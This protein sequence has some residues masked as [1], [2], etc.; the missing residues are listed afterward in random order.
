MSS[1]DANQTYSRLLESD[2]G[3]LHSKVASAREI[4]RRLPSS[5]ERS[6]IASQAAEALRELREHL[7]GHFRQEEAEGC[8]HE[9]V[10]RCPRLSQKAR[11]ILS[12]HGQLLREADR[13]I[14]QVETLKANRVDRESLLSGFEE[15]ARALFAHESD[16]RKLLLEGF[17]GSSSF[18]T[19]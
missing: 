5:G 11:L 13:L 15:L 8:L 10:G 7:D 16:E 9:A 4:L 18:D 19:I 14:A 1:Y 12:E 2:H 6:E 3:R 17:G